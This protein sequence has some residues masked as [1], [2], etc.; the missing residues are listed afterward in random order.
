LK[1]NN[2]KKIILTLFVML[3][4]ACS[5]SVAESYSTG[6]EVYEARCSACHGKDFEGR[7]GPALDAGSQSASMPDSYWVQTITKGKGSMPAQRLTDNE[8]TMVIEYIRSNH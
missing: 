5:S 4:M 8:V 3:F 1:K 7:V 6:E 2:L